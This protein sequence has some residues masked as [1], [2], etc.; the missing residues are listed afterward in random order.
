MIVNPTAPIG[1]HDVKP[2]PTGK[3]VLDFLNGDMPAFI[4]TGLNVV[5]VRDTAEGH[6][7]ACERGRPGERYILG[8]ENLTLAQILQKLAAITGRK[9]PTMRLPYAV[10]YCAG[11]CSTAWAGSPGS[12]RGCR[13]TRVRMA[14]KKM[15]VTH[16]KAAAN[17]DSHPG[18]AE[19][20]LRRP[21][22]GFAPAGT[23]RMRILFVAADRMEFAGMLR[24]AA[25]VRRASCRSISRARARLAAHEVLLV[26]NGAGWKRAAAAVDAA[27]DGFAP[28]AIV[29]TGFCGA[30]DG[31]CG[32]PTSL[33]ATAVVANG[34]T[35]TAP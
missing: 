27:C 12:R 9:A 1:D 17:W 3:I 14:R 31:R 13:S 28:D 10:A 7:L 20:A 4:D 15:W 11:A 34:R 5:D 32:S 18:P 19:V 16:E 21:W 25:D 23:R 30:L 35:R 29:S 8:S 22:S 26:A 24:R 33:A 6:L 2:T